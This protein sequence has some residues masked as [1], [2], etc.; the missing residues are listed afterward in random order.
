MY[1]HRQGKVN[2]DE[3]P[4]NKKNKRKRAKQFDSFIKILLALFILLHIH[5]YARTR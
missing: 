5:L 4:R 3:E 1:R 2:D